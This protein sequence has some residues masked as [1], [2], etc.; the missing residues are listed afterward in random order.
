MV[1]A[2]RYA[3]IVAGGR[4]TRM[5]SSVPKQFLLLRGRPILMWTLDAF[6]AYD[7]GVRL[8]VVLPKSEQERWKVLC[9]AYG[10]VTPCLMADGGATRFQSVANALRLIP[11]DEGDA[12]IA[13][14]DGV[15]PFVTS[16]VIAACYDEAARTGAAVPVTELTDS[17]R[18]VAGSTSQAVN[19]GDYRL[20]Q[21]PQT[22]RANVLKSAY[23]LPYRA[24]FTDDASVVEAAGYA[25]RLVPGCREN[26]K[27][28]TPLGMAFAQAL[29]AANDGL[30]RD[31]ARQ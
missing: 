10:F 15:R 19:R 26:F 7:A 3:V 22:F 29:L 21:T 4:G 18:N 24:T 8:I 12:L 20:V 11:D 17:L 28:T 30:R 14:H 25:V 31:S 2:K 9:R 23:C 5:Q 1:A 16:R 13:V 6:M 27:I